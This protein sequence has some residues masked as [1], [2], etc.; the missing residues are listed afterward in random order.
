M[1]VLTICLF[2]AEYKTL[3]QCALL[4]GRDLIKDAFETMSRPLVSAFSSS[5]STLSSLVKR[6]LQS[7]IFMALAVYSSLS[8]VQEQYTEILLRRTGRKDNDLS[9]GIHA[10]RGLC[11]RSF[12]ELLLEIKTPAMSPPTAT[13]GR[14]EIG[15]GIADVTVMVS[16]APHELQV[17][18]LTTN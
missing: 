1:V 2:K 14:G 10:L 7:N 12:P 13:P 8:E 18:Q 9:T 5:L 15:T 6:N 11:I 16:D 4:P 17:R 3:I